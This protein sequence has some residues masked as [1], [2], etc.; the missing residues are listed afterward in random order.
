MQWI[1]TSGSD[2]QEAVESALFQLGIS[3]GELEYTVISEP[4]RGILGIG[5]AEARIRAR[6]KPTTFKSKEGGNRRTRTDRKSVKKGP[7]SAKAPQSR[8]KATA[9]T[10][11]ADDKPTT[12]RSRDAAEGTAS[13]IPAKKAAQK[14]STAVEKKEKSG[15]KK[16]RPTPSLGEQRPAKKASSGRRATISKESSEASG[17]APRAEGASTE[18]GSREMPSTDEPNSEALVSVSLDE[19]AESAREFLEGLLDEFDL[20]AEVVIQR[21]EEDTAVVCVEGEGLGLLIGPKASTLSAIQELTR[22]AVQRHSG[23]SNG[24]LLVDVGGYRAKRKVA[25][26]GFA[27]RIASDVIAAGEEK[28]LEPMSPAD[29]KVIH[30]SINQ[31]SGVGTRSEGEEP[32]RRVVVFPEA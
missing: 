11:G 29:R 24:R 31:I 2:I 19:Q 1:E 3:R 28:S 14:V 30:D 13:A 5:K 12:R 10:A 8:S 15:E 18:K 25:L 21:P 16:D 4:R 17:D 22:T 9:K 6:V 27:T 7:S 23:G 20:D 32:Y 26:E